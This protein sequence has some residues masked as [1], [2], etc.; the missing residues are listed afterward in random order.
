MTQDSAMNRAPADDG[1][2]SQAIDLACAQGDTTRITDS[3]DDDHDSQSVVPG[4]LAGLAQQ[5]LDEFAAQ[6]PAG[7]A[8]HRAILKAQKGKKKKGKKKKAMKK[9]FK[10]QAQKG[11]KKKAMKKKATK[12]KFEGQADAEEQDDAEQVVPPTHPKKRSKAKAKGKNRAR[13]AKGNSTNKDEDDA[14]DDDMPAADEIA[15]FVDMAKDILGDA[16]EPERASAKYKIK[17]LNERGRLFYQVKD[18]K[19]TVIQASTAHFDGH[20]CCAAHGLLKLHHMGYTKEQLNMAKLNI[21]RRMKA[22]KMI[23][24]CMCLARL[25][26]FRFQEVA[27]TIA[28]PEEMQL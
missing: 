15:A 19:S 3:A 28:I 18:G 12:K 20:S 10:G 1:H 5:V 14:D 26:V 17:T 6:G 13:A 11:K 9:K 22:A 24:P 23:R 8:E 27:C 4:A 16:Q 25:L 7:A 2:D 21:A